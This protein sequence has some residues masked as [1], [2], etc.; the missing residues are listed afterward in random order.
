MKSKRHS[1]IVV[2][3]GVEKGDEGCRLERDLIFDG[4]QVVIPLSIA[5]YF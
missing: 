4:D 2:A 5:V 1:K 3:S